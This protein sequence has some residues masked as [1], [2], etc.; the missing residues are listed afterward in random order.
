[1]VC[2]TQCASNVTGSL[3]ASLDGTLDTSDTYRRDVPACE[4]DSAVG[5]SHLWNHLGQVARPVMNP[6][7]L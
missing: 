6:S 5:P 2:A 3:G 1:M 4:M 7:A